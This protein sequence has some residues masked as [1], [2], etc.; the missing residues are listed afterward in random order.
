MIVRELLQW[1][2]TASAGER[3]DGATALAR[4]Y[5]L[6]PLSLDDRAAG[7][8]AM[9]M[10]LDDPAPLVR[11]ALAEAFASSPAAPPAVVH[12]LAADQPFVAVPILERSPL[13]V[14]ADLV[15]MVATGHREIV[16]AIARRP[17][18]Q[19]SVAAAIAEVG[20]AEACLELIENPDADI[21]PF[22]IDRIVARYGHLA[23]IRE[24]LLAADNLPVATRQALVAKLS[25]TLA[26]FVAA[27][28]WLAKD[29]ALRIATE[30]CEKATVTIAADTV[31]VGPLVRH[32]RETGQL[33]AGLVLRALLCGNCALFEESL[34]ELSGVSLKRV[35][36]LVHGKCNAGFRALYDKAGLPALAYPAFREA[37]E[38]MHED[39]L[40]GEAGDA[41]RLKRRMVERVLTRCES[42]MPGDVEALM[43]LL[44][45]FATEAAREEARMLCDKLMDMSAPHSPADYDF[46]P[47]ERL[48]AA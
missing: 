44:R 43:T 12:G 13:F 33:T 46:V 16:A 41:S 27:R 45:R 15:D 37:I 19:R 22:S 2:R 10:L 42:S 28:A 31:E 24:S 21:A 38:A 25:Q 23:A 14:D 29:R 20:P 6:S 7:E 39:V 5:L 48:V 36:G 35:Y 3:A 32:L 26:D 17:M 40:L 30:A 18:L 11:R 47:G 9:L 1:L 8:G 34:A 4:A